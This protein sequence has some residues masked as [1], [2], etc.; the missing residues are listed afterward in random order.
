MSERQERRVSVY[1]LTDEVSR[2]EYEELINS[3]SDRVLNQSEYPM[4]DGSVLRV[5]DHVE[6]RND[7][8][9]IYTPPIC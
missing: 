5:V 6:K 4:G 3:D 1:D 9:P 7:K 8:T 2:G